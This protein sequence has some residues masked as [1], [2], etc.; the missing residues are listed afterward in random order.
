MILIPVFIAVHDSVLVL[1]LHPQ[2]VLFLAQ[3]IHLLIDLL[4]LFTCLADSFRSLVKFGIILLFFGL[5]GSQ[6]I[7]L[8]GHCLFN[9]LFLL[10]LSL[11]RILFY[12]QTVGIFD[13]LFLLLH[14]ILTLGRLL[15]LLHLY[16]GLKNVDGFSHLSFFQF[17]FFQIHGGLPFIDFETL[18]LFLQI[19]DMLLH[20]VV[21][22]ELRCQFL[23]KLANLFFEGCDFLCELSETIL[24]FNRLILDDIHILNFGGHILGE[25]SQFFFNFKEE[26]FQFTD[27]VLKSLQFSL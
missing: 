4:Q 10:L 24:K 19:L 3:I 18:Q 14:H 11:D 5:D 1:D 6:E 13:R 8:I 26:V 22:K 15:L 17:V 23:F 20:L 9:F 27:G 2:L 21:A 16:A 12:L 7:G 25:V